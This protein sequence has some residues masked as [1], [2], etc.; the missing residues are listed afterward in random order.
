V[1]YAE[2]SCKQPLRLPGDTVIGRVCSLVHWFIF[3]AFATFVV[4]SR[5]VKVSFSWNWPEIYLC[6]ASVPNVTGWGQVSL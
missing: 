1:S 6:S 4:I 5:K 3:R 2:Y